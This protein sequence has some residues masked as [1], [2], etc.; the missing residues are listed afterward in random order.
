MHSRNFFIFFSVSD[1]SVASRAFIMVMG[2]S[3]PHVAAI[4]GFQKRKKRENK[5]KKKEI[6]RQCFPLVGIMPGN[7][8]LFPFAQKTKVV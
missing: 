3:G 7:Q 8:S 1:C 4:F 2:R 5:R 6:I